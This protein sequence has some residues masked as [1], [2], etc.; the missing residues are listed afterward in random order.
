MAVA[1]S[2]RYVETGIMGIGFDADESLPP[3]VNTYPN[4]IDDMVAQDLINTRAYSLWLDDLGR[5]GVLSRAKSQFLPKLSR[6]K[7]GNGAVQGYDANKYTGEAM[8]LEI[9]PGA[10][11]GKINTMTVA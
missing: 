4:I 3:G 11:S 10:N 7:Y 1:T 2:M 9:Q 5:S 6:H 8:A